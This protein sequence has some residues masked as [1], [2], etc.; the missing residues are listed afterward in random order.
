MRCCAKCQAE[1]IVRQAVVG[2]KVIPHRHRIDAARP[3]GADGAL[4]VG[5]HE[6]A[7]AVGDEADQRLFLARREEDIGFVDDDHVIIG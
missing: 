7:A 3:L 5:D 1:W 2:E 6:Q 4:M